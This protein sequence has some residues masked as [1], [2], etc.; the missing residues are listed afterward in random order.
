MSYGINM[1]RSVM[2]L[3]FVIYT[4][5]IPSDSMAQNNVENELHGKKSCIRG[6]WPGQTGC[7]SI[8][9]GLSLELPD[10]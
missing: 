5:S 2:I 8:E 1:T 9:N 10:F 3:F 4:K 7:T 6:F